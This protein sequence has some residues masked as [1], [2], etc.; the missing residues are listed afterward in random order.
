MISV[1]DFFSYKKNRPFWRNVVGMM[2]CVVLLLLCL[3]WWIGWYTHHGEVRQVPDV[4]N[5]SFTEAKD[6]LKRE[7]FKIVIA[8]SSYMPDL[9]EGTVLEQTPKGLAKVKIGRTI[10]LVVSS[11]QV[12]LVRLP[13]II[14][15]TS[16]RQAEAKLRAMGFQIDSTEYVAGESEWVY[17]VKWK[18]QSM[19]NGDKLPFKALLTIVA[20]SVE[21]RDSILVDT[22]YQHIPMEEYREDSAKTTR[23]DE[24][25]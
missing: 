9:P 20:G 23:E 1:K 11:T 18:G 15:N 10:Y 13:E 21:I 14:D 12:P 17:G 5:K 24:W 8:D 7:D 2:L 4:L 3:K 6:I 16:L 25:F 22:F 19:K